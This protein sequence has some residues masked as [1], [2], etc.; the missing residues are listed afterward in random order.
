MQRRGSQTAVAVVIVAVVLSGIPSAWADEAAMTQVAQV[1][2]SP[3]PAA[4]NLV[5]L[6]FKDADLQNVLRAIAQKAKVNIVSAKGIEGTVTIRLDDV[7]WETALDTI[8]KT[9]DLGYDRDGNVILVMTREELL[10]KHEMERELTTQEPLIAKVIVLKYLDAADV[11]RF[12]QP[13]LSPQGRISVLEVTGQRGWTFGISSGKKSEKPKARAERD[14]S[15]SKALLITDTL[16]T[17]RRLEQILD[18]VDVK[19]TQILIEAR[20]MEVNRDLVRDLGLDFAT[21]GQGLTNATTTIT[22]SPFLK[23]SGST[24][25]SFGAQSLTGFITPTTFNPKTTAITSSNTG[26]KFEFQRLTGLQFDVMLRALEEDAKAN[27]LSA[28]QVLTLS[29]QEARI[30]VGTK[31]PILKT[32]VSGTDTTTTTTTLDYYQ[33]IGIQLYV[34]PQV[35]DDQYIDM[36]IHPV[37][38]SFTTTLGTNAYPIILAR[39]AETQMVIEDGDTVVLGGLLKDVKTTD[40]VGLPFVSKLPLIGLLFSRAQIDVEKIDLLIFITARI[41]RFDQFTPEELAQLKAKY[42]TPMIVEGPLG[43]AGGGSSKK[44]KSKAPKAKSSRR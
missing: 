1:T 15:R 3:E 23:R 30:V 28:P 36:I 14:I 29:G 20:V 13:Q 35:S 43:P 5:S 10:R 38:S 40:R 37:V 16:T 2:P 17:V 42:E 19:P 26:L 7:P 9:A 21:G 18:R 44:G 8:L 22:Q 34:V 24:V 39:E 32:S 4:P 25:A 11:Q 27:T 41:V 33:D 12:L 31:Y 6:D